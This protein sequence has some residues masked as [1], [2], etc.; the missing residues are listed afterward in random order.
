M[1]KLILYI[2]ASVN[3]KI[4]GTDGSV[5]WLDAFSNPDAGD[6][7]YQEF[8]EGVDTTIQGNATYKQILDW[9]I[10]FPY[11]G[12]SNYV[13]TANPAYL[14]NDDV[15]FISSDHKQ[16]IK[17][18]KQQEGKDIWLIGGGKTNSA[19]LSAGLIDEIRLFVMPI[20]L[21]G[22]IETFDGLPA[23]TKLTLEESSTFDGGVLA[24]VYSVNNNQST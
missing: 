5:A 20:V 13:F 22:G 4:A 23:E 7:G 12:K 3:G 14:D 16:F 6:Y 2:A 8:Y 10:E 9:G 21:Q 18:L 15:K 1:R 24:L 19:M 17:D 11:K